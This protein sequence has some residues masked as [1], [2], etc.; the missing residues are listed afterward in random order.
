MNLLAPLFLL[1]L[2]A[3]ALPLWL[4]RLTVQSPEREAFSSSMLL[5]ASEQ[6]IHLRRKLRYLLLLALRVSLLILLALAFAGPVLRFPARMVEN[7]S[8]ILHLVVIDNSFSMQAGD[9]FSKAMSEARSVIEEM[10]PGDGCSLILAGAAT[11]FLADNESDPAVLVAALAALE[12]G[13]GRLD[14]GTLMATLDGIVSETR[15]DILLHLISDF[16]ASGVPARF[17]ELVPEQDGERRVGLRLHPVASGLE[18]NRFVSQVRRDQGELEVSV[19]SRADGPVEVHLS[20]TING[21]NRQELSKTQEG[22]GEILFRFPDQA[23]ARGDNRVTA[24]LLPEDAWSGDNRYHAVIDNSDLK[25]V[26]LLTTDPSSRA[27]TYLET[28]LATGLTDYRAEPVRIADLDPRILQRYAWIMIE[29]LG[30]VNGTLATALIGYLENGGAILAALGEHTLTRAVLPVGGQAVAASALNSMVS[31]GRTVAR[32]DT[33]HPVLKQGASWRNVNIANMFV[34]QGGAD[35]RGL[36]FMD[37]GDPLLLEHRRGSGRMLLFAS[38]LDNTW[39]DLPVH[40]VFV[41]FLSEA[42]IFLAEE[43]SLERQRLAGSSLVLQ[44]A[45]YASGQVIDPE[46]HTILTLAD[47]RLSQEIPLNR[48]GFYQ[49]Y[50]PGRERLI[51]VNTDPRESEPV[52]MS[53]ASMQAWQDAVTGRKADDSAAI[54]TPA[55]TADLPIWEW[56]LVLL[57]IIALLESLLGNAHLVYR[58]GS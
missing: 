19:R 50:T 44:Q 58:A 1:G 27:V 4:H 31:G 18:G 5:E 56:I 57:V 26:L 40:P 52:I 49:V 46:G 24:E 16:Q 54:S 51:A 37:N 15:D 38:S 47:T 33:S 6:R 8:T 28:A 2:G 35:D 22:E 36:V 41:S 3:V 32:I 10:Q 34:I 30:A 13:D 55:E 11:T 17:S 25:P 9:R 21:E 23:F 7:T 29:D 42:G 43:D 53:E 45:G 14:L 48:K 12:P 20:I 39:N